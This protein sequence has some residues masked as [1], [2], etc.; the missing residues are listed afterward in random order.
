M[1]AQIPDTISYNQTEYEL[2]SDPLSDYFKKYGYKFN[3][4][5]PHTAN[6][7]GYTAEWIIDN[8]VL[9]LVGFKGHLAARHSD[10][11]SEVGLEMFGLNK[12]QS[13]D[14]TWFS[15]E[16]HLQDG[17]MLEY[18]HAGWESIY[19]RELIL[20]IE[21][22]VLKNKSVVDNSEL[23]QERR[24]KREENAAEEAQSSEQVA[25]IL[26]RWLP[27]SKR[28]MKGKYKALM[29]GVVVVVATLL[30]ILGF[31]LIIAYSLYKH[32]LDVRSW[33]LWW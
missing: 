16:L 28:S 7:R 17:A 18:I 20:T 5:A 23:V 3:L 10:L 14:A 13:L 31:P 19:E 1:T 24:R 32:V 8:D 9:K 6:W 12:G 26:E 22:G 4:S 25:E 11:G 29:N 21:D 33:K 30:F 2:F 15:G 27:F